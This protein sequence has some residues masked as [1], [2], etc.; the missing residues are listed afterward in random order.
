MKCV[1]AL[2][3]SLEWL[4][5]TEK[6]GWFGL[7]DVPLALELMDIST[8]AKMEMTN[9]YLDGDKN[10]LKSLRQKYI[11]LD[12][13]RK[14]L[15]DHLHLDM[16]QKLLVEGDVKAVLFWLSLHGIATLK[17]ASAW[18]FSDDYKTISKSKFYWLALAARNDEM[19]AEVVED[20]SRQTYWNKW[21]FGSHLSVS[22]Q[23]VE[24]AAQAWDMDSF[25]VGLAE[26]EWKKRCTRVLSNIK[27]HEA[28]VVYGLLKI[29]RCAWGLWGELALDAC[30]SRNMDGWLATLGERAVFIR[31]SQEKME[32]WG[33][34]KRWVER[35]CVEP[36]LWP[37]WKS[38]KEFLE[39]SVVSPPMDFINECDARVMKS[40]C[41]R[42]LLGLGNKKTSVGKVL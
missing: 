18:G 7:Q 26:V 36:Q 16:A 27:G 37:K 42:R 21:A 8:Q 30:D 29:D 22:G 12:Q 38:T 20:A 23:P 17:T 24:A 11:F 19:W 10:Q 15:V 14:S 33:V 2:A 6:Y 41:G 31:G 1:S 9:A 34:I 25:D 40:K 28:E 5:I 39:Q 3:R 35:F 13:P 4:E 32:R